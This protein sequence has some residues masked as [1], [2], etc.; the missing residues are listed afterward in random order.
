MS[1]SLEADSCAQLRD[2]IISVY[3]A[4]WLALWEILELYISTDILNWG[5]PPVLIGGYPAFIH[6]L[7]E[8]DT[9]PDVDH[10]DY[11]K[12]CKRLLKRVKE[13][14]RMDGTEVKE[15]LF[16]SLMKF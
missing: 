11:L 14:I 4:K 2:H 7:N 3:P 15:T 13:V 16:E 8:L 1:L 9:S 6:L 10:V 5:L 12:A